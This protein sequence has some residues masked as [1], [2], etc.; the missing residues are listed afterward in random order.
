MPHF[1]INNTRQ[2]N[3]PTTS[4]HPPTNE[5]FVLWNKNQ[6]CTIHNCMAKSVLHDNTE[7]IFCARPKTSK[8]KAVAFSNRRFAHYFNSRLH[9][10]IA[11]LMDCMRCW[12]LT[13]SLFCRCIRNSFS[14]FSRFSLMKKQNKRRITQKR[15]SWRSFGLPSG[16]W[17]RSSTLCMSLIRI[18]DWDASGDPSQFSLLRHL[19]S[20][21]KPA[22]FAV[23]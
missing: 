16:K 12:I 15:P 5:H 11:S 3:Y 20:C 9:D 6:G 14:S 19:Q 4:W 2:R 7:I 1:L 13:P 17:M 21:C 10:V 18:S 8:H 23:K 22:Y